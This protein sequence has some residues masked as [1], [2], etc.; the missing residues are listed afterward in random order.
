MPQGK[1]SNIEVTQLVE[2]FSVTPAGVMIRL[3]QFMPE[4]VTLN[5]NRVS[6]KNCLSRRSV[7]GRC[8]PNGRYVTNE[9][10]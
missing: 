2:K 8:L 5:L 9:V 6:H 4:G 1:S 3:S 7:F 10:D